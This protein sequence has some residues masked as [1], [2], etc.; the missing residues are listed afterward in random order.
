MKINMITK[1]KERVR[2]K[3]VL[4]FSGGM[5]SIIFNKLLNPDI[6]LY[7]PT[8]ASYEQIETEK[9]NQ[10]RESG[11]IDSDKLIVC[12]GILDLQQF[13]RDDAI[14]PNRNAFL[15]LIASMYGEELYLSSV[16]GDRSMD[17]DFLFYDRMTLLLDHMWQK[18]H[19]TEKRKFFIKSP[20]KD[21]TKTELVNEFLLKGGISDTL[22]KSYSCYSGGEPVCGQCKPC[23]RKWVSLINNNIEI[24]SGYYINN[25]WEASWLKELFPLLLD[26]SYRGKEDLDWLKAL[27]KVKN[28]IIIGGVGK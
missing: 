9:I 12:S 8:K 1:G 7:I 26:S 22:I 28:K 3:S 23:F 15:L 19:W 18:Q 25:P 2:G 10:L 5:D 17:K 21:K 6:L 4:L 27:G 11:E 20:F 13:E 24:P 14:V 16:N